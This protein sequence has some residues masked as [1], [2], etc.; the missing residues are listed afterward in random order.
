ME[1]GVCAGGN[2][3]GQC[4]EDNTVCVADTQSQCA[5]SNCKPGLC[6]CKQ[7][8][9]IGFDGSCTKGNGNSFCRM[10]LL[11]VIVHKTKHN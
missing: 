4:S 7:D 2:R 11:L 10:Q 1:G 8:Y 3:M 5:G 9:S 6:K